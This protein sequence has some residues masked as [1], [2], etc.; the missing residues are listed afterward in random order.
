MTSPDVLSLLLIFS[1]VYPITYIYIRLIG[2]AEILSSVHIVY[3]HTPLLTESQVS[4][5]LV[6]LPDKGVDSLLVDTSKLTTLA[7]LG[8]VITASRLLSDKSADD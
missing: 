6:Y 8:A 1:R 7:S 2:I 5:A 4:P 3:S